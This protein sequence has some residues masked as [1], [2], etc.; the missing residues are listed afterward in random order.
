MARNTFWNFLGVLIPSLAALPAIGYLAR[1]LGVE[2]FGLLTLSFAIIGY[3]SIFD[4]GLSRA[5]IREVALSSDKSSEVNKA[6][7]TSSVVVTI[8]GFTCALLL[9][10]NSERLASSL[11]VT[12]GNWPDVVLGLNYL[13]FAIVPLLLSTVWFSFLEGRGD[14][15]NLNFL[16][17][18]SG[19][20]VAIIPAAWVWISGD[21]RFSVAMLGLVASRIFVM[22]LAYVFCVLPFGLRVHVF[23]YFTFKR[24]INYG[25]WI[26]VSNF[27]SPVMVYFDRFFISSHLGAA[28]VALYSAPSEVIGRV[29]FVPTSISR[30]IFQRLSLDSSDSIQTRV[31][32][33]MTFVVCG[34]SSALIFFGSDI[35]LSVWLGDK[36]LGEASLVLKILAVGFLFNSLAQIPFAKIQAEGNSRL[37]AILHIFE[38]LPYLALLYFLVLHSSIVGAA[39]AWTVRV[40]VDFLLLEYFSRK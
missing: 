20:A 39:I 1:V 29:A 38:V 10:F 9:Y 23:D 3:A 18:I 30:V 15:R 24:L 19:L 11:G 7:G 2:N 4:L 28:T 22:L 5:V 8:A 12:A 25:G 33:K 16:K 36:Y 17:I 34:L 40:S 13:S 37:T 27:I 6:V 26:T 31:A 21:E 14:F 32:Y 35:I